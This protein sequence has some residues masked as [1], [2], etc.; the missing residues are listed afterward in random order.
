MPHNAWSLRESPASA[1]DFTKTMEFKKVSVCSSALL[2]L[3]L[4]TWVEVILPSTGSIKLFSS[5]KNLF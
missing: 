2:I 1:E 4:L 3:D 5:S